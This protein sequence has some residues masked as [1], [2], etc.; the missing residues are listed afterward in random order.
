MPRHRPGNAQEVRALVLDALADGT[1]LQIEGGASKRALHAPVSA[2][3]IL[4]TSGLSGVLDYDPEELVIR[5]QAGT[6]L[7]EIEA[8]LAERQ[9]MFAFDPFDHALWCAGSAA[10]ATIGG[11]V[12]ANVSGPRRVS[13]GAARDHLLGFT[14]VSGRGEV[15]K[16]GGA[17][18]KNVSGFDL[19]KLMAG[20]FG[21]LAVLT[22]LTLRVVPR[23][24]T[25]QSLRFWGLSE[26]DANRLMTSA[27]ATPAAVSAAAH[28]PAIGASQAQT[29]LRLEGFGPSV[30]AR[31]L[32][33]ER[34][35]EPFGPAE[36]V[37]E[38]ESRQAWRGVSTLESL[39]REGSVWWRVCVPPAG[40][41]KVRRA[42]AEQGLPGLYD[43]G[44]GLVWLAVPQE[45]P[46]TL[47]ERIRLEARRLGGHAS[48]VAAH[49]T[50][51]PRASSTA[52]PLQAL[53]ERVKAAFDPRGV[54]NPGIDLAAELE[55]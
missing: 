29:L 34:Q 51:A 25:E 2:E 44:G 21:T 46:A 48:C 32:L 31:A 43:W 33:L 54:L 28:L 6:P 41:F 55:H 39:P 23:P 22:S 52:S 45:A 53:H 40:G 15:L 38:Q 12:A 37:A 5:V 3:A 35:L 13:S 14:A 24:R 16:G 27:L 30:E 49:S 50:R 42:L 4:D 17:V 36:R 11:I 26:P 7:A 18:V 1:R 19:P 8:V 9:Q 10:R 47:G 20:S